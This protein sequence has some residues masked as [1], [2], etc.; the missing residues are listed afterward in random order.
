MKKLA[1]LI[2]LKKQSLDEKRKK[3]SEWLD[4]IYKLKIVADKLDEDLII[5]QQIIKEFNSFSYAYNNYYQAN[6]QNKELM[7]NESS[8]YQKLIS[9]LQDE[10][11]NDFSELKKLEILQRNHK[12]IEEQ[13]IQK[14]EQANLDEIALRK[15]TNG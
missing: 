2:K 13:R 9:N 3:L 10:I 1:I 14:I 4:H 5:E 11:L 7:I 6:R 15:F 8:K 12:I